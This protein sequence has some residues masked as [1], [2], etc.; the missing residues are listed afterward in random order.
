MFD[1][2]SHGALDF[3]EFASALSVFHPIAPIDDKIECKCY[4]Y[5]F[6][7]LASSS[8]QFFGPGSHVVRKA[9]SYMC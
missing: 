1:T 2:N 9:H 5:L 6:N 3:K 4:K 8:K 7:T